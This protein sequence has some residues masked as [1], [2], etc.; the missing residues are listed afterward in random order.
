VTRREPDDHPLTL[1]LVPLLAVV[2]VAAAGCEG[3]PDRLPATAHDL[4]VANSDTS[5]LACWLRW[6]TDEPS[7]S[8]VEFGVG[9]YTHFVEDDTLVQD[10]EIAVYGLRPHTEYQLRATSR[11]ADDERGLPATAT[12]QTRGVPFDDALVE[13]TSLREDLM[14][15]GWTLTNLAFSAGN[16]EVLAVIYDEEGYPVWYRY[17]GHEEGRA[18]VVMTLTQNDNVL[19]GGAVAAGRGPAEV[20]LNGTVRWEGFEQPTG[21]A[22]AGYMHHSFS[23]LTN[24]HY[25][26]LRYGYED[27]LRDIIEEFDADLQTVWFFNLSDHREEMGENYTHGNLAWADI[28]GGAVYYSARGSHYVAKIDRSTED[29]LWLLGLER[30]FEMVGGDDSAW[31]QHQHAPEITDDGTLLI[32]DNGIEERAF[33]RVIEYALDEDAMTA[34]VVWE[35]PGE[36]AVDEWWQGKWGDADRQPNGNTLITAGSPNENGDAV[37]IFEVTPDGTLAWELWME[38]EDPEQSYGFYMAERIPVLI[39]EI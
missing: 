6:Q 13:V 25:M 21:L 9:A 32:F 30:D 19:M 7:T 5:F 24:G 14:E 3:D 15:P 29:V 28:D 8:Y 31:F 2:L 11:T 35:Y 26:A 39:Q 10:H 16:T 23:K 33:S 34:E 12:Y 18:D 20:S 4:E 17:L 36:I 22:P 27:G 37:R 1:P 38:P